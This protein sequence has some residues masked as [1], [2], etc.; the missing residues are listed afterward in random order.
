MLGDIL[1]KP[2]IKSSIRLSTKGA[3]V[4]TLIIGA[5][6]IDTISKL[7]EYRMND[8]NPG[9]TRTS[10]GGVGY[11]I[12]L[13][14]TYSGG[15]VKFVSVIGD[16]Y[17]GKVL[18]SQTTINHKLYI[19]PGNSANYI[20]IHN[21]QGELII[22]SA[23]M[24]IIETDFFDVTQKELKSCQPDNVV[25][26]CNISLNH[27][28]QIYDYTPAKLIIEP[29]SAYKAHKLGDLNISVHKPVELI[30]PTVAELNTIYDRLERNDRFDDEWFEIIDSLELYRV[31]NMLKG[32]M[33]KQLHEQGIIQKA[34]KLLPYF[35]NIIIKLGEKGV[36]SLGV[37]TSSLF[38]I[39]I[40]NDTPFYIIYD[41]IPQENENIQVV[42]VTG[43][44]D[45]LL[46]YIIANL[47]KPFAQ[48]IYKAQLLSGLSLQ[49][50]HA[51]S[52]KIKYV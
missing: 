38:N 23:D 52:E 15:N 30:M 21:P 25:V 8:S 48:M 20:S 50:H 26:D 6:A 39:E 24:K 42:N 19:K 28:Q 34:F 10:I 2:L 16:D 41:P 37:R 11:N 51:V 43:A 29:T 32:G 47:D 13:A 7:D 17:S 12:A 40:P 27:L 31:G 45:T 35:S 49:S 33:L 5:V 4:D 1:N 18:Q 9:N 14:C 44:G 46:G 22:A 36:L 3:K